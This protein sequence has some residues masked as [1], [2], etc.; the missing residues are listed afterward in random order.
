MFVLETRWSWEHYPTQT[1]T[2]FQPHAPPWQV[3]SHPFRGESLESQILTIMSEQKM[4]LQKLW[5]ET[6]IRRSDSLCSS[7]CRS[8]FQLAEE[9]EETEGKHGVWM[10]L[11]VR[12]EVLQPA[13]SGGR[14]MRS[15]Q[16]LDSWGQTEPRE[17]G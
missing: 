10:L 9:R 15:P 12:E 1:H 6:K 17:I 3:G 5:E 13:P 4:W 7:T 8:P 2:P 16:S 11:G 14:G